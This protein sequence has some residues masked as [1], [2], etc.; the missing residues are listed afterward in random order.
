[1]LLGAA[2]RVRGDWKDLTP[3]ALAEAKAEGVHDRRLWGALESEARNL[4]ALEIELRG[5]VDWTL[6][7]T[8]SLSALA[9]LADVAGGLTAVLVTRCSERGIA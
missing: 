9:R 2:S 6:L 8:D 7:A 4:R 1:M 3:A 5:L